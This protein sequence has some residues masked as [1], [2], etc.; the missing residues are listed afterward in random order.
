MDIVKETKEYLKYVR[1]H[2]CSVCPEQ[3]VDADHLDARGRGGGKRKGTHT[4]TLID[5]TCIPLCRLHHTERHATTLREFEEKYR[6][7]LWK[8]SSKMVRDFYVL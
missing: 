3:Q 5:F 2:P 1:S 6:T 7:N 4:G 8:I